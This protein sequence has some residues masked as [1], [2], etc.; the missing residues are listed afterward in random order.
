MSGP[1]TGK[2][3]LIHIEV[4]KPEVSQQQVAEEEQKEVDPLEDTPPEDPNKGFVP[5]DLTEEDRLLYT[6]LAIENDCNIVP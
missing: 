5:R 2:S 6:V 1:F 3:D 4:P